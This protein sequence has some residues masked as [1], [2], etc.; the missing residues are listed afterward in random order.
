M[1]QLERVHRVAVATIHERMGNP[2]TKDNVQMTYTKSDDMAA[3][4]YTKA[5]VCPG[6]W[7]KAIALI[8][9]TDPA[10]VVSYVSREFR[11]DR[12]DNSVTKP[13][14][15]SSAP[16]IVVQRG[17]NGPRRTNAT[18][19]RAISWTRGLLLSWSLDILVSW[20][21]GFLVCQAACNNIIRSNRN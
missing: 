11:G 13:E 15:L 7:A 3:D 19:S 12:E 10:D 20:F 17:L 5:F 2:E 4:I 18:P 16:G 6:K 1:R 21:C 9:L 14:N 8:N